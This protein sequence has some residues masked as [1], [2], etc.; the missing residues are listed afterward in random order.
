MMS[1]FFIRYS[2]SISSIY[3]SPHTAMHDTKRSGALRLLRRHLA[4]H[5]EASQRLI[6]NH[7][8]RTHKGGGLHRRNADREEGTDDGG[9]RAARGG[10]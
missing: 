3:A 4:R 9:E 10:D 8:A 6:V 7:P 5:A 1:S 2:A